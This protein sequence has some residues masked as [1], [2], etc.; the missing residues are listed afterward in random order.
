MEISRLV[1]VHALVLACAFSCK[2]N[3][4]GNAENNATSK[5][6]AKAQIGSF[7]D[8]GDGTYI[9]PI[10]NADYPDS[11]IEQVAIPIT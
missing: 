2:S 1:V 7:G 11:D 6:I 5:N 10:L 8:Q 4:K 3:S 9:N